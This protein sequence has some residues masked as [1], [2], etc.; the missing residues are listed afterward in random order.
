MFRKVLLSALAALVCCGVWSA[1]ADVDFDQGRADVKE[2]LQLP[3]KPAI[4]AQAL[5]SDKGWWW[6]STKKEWTVMVYI[7]GK[8]NLETYGLGDVNEMEKVGSND[9]MNVV[10]ELGRIDGSGGP[11]ADWK[12]IR[13]Y[14]VQKDDDPN[15]ITSP[16]VQQFTADM[17]SSQHLYDFAKWAMEKYPA[18]H[19]MV[20]VW[21]HGSGWAKEQGFK[22][23]TKG[24]SYDDETGNHIT[25]QQLGATLAQ[26][27]H[28]DVYA[29]DACLMQM[30]SVGYEMKDTVDVIVGSEETEP[31]DGYDYT[32]FLQRLAA[33]PA[34]GAEDVGRFV[35]ESYRDFYAKKNQATTQSALRARAFPGLVS[36][37]NQW[38]TLALD[39]AEAA[40]V[41]AAKSDAVHFADWD[42][43]DLHHLVRLITEK[44]ANPALKQK[45]GELL[46]YIETSLV[47]ANGLSGD[48]FKDARGLAIY[49]PSY[50]Y[51]NDYDKLKWAR[52]TKW[53]AF[54]KSA[55]QSLN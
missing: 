1:A 3:D 9:K 46:S 47:V 42:S 2:F 22:A 41:K 5:S 6:W 12:G 50:G 4:D 34:A 18:K 10:V 43:R 32:G 21:N 39:P 37:L 20:I 31:G 55:P 26:L 15:K 19:Y 17:G 7:N 36:I 54:I 23:W 30:A 52:D 33:R 45:G 13:R 48:K 53:P 27:G 35:V 51:N 49:T 24:I 11:D 29:S 8:N 14:L 16:V 28:I 40:N 25:T 44:T 38:V